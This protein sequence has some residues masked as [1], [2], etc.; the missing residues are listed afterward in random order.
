MFFRVFVEKG[1]CFFEIFINMI[2]VGEFLG[3]FDKMLERMVM[4][5]EK[6]LKLK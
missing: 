4:Y 1:E 2:E 5:F 6:E 3:L